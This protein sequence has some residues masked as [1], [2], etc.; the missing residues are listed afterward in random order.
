MRP[1]LLLF[2]FLI[3][4]LLAAQAQRNFRVLHA[5]GVGNDGAGVWDSVTID[6]SG[7]VYG[8]TSGRGAY[9]GGTVFRLTPRSGGH[10]SETILHNFG[11]Q[12][13]GAG[14]LGGVL[15]GSSGVL[16]GTTETGGG[17]RT[18]GI[19]YSLSP[20]STGWRE[21]VLHRFRFGDRAG[22]SWG[23]VV[24]DQ[25]GNLYGT[26]SSVFELSPGQ[27][28]W[29]ETIL[30][31][32]VGGSGDGSG[33]QA[34]PIRDAAG[35]LYGTTVYGGGSHECDGGCGT[36]WE[37]SP[38]AQ[39]SGTLGW[40][41]HLLHRFGY[42]HDGG[43]PGGGQLAL[44]HEG[45]LYGTTQSG[46]PRRAGTVFKLARPQAPSGGWTETILH[47][48]AEDQDGYLPTGGV[49]LDSA[50]NLYGTTGVGGAYGQGVVFKLS[51]QPD[52][53]WKYT[54]L[55][56]FV[57]TDGSQPDANLTLGPDGKLY[58]TTATGGAHGGGVVFQLTP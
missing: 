46:G 6:A 11:R 30:H 23:N 36:A 5:F 20:G 43:F 7:N 31:E 37:L 41:E 32:F 35:N 4:P 9:G 16:Y 1:K 45:N 53:S 34:G 50:G 22:S 38:T 55:H 58:G 10:W 24:M 40:T 28:G 26:G 8:T 56:T 21:T 57:G 48:F 52:G 47:G 3:L 12:N 15:I 13:D 49:I 17:P 27:N 54:L 25:S 51:P 33:P 39:G 29:A 14:P 44:D 19:V 42:G 2:A 18:G